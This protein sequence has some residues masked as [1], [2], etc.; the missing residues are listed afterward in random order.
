LKKQLKAKLQ[1]CATI[2]S[3]NADL[4]LSVRKL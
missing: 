3:S 2:I 1:F 4:H